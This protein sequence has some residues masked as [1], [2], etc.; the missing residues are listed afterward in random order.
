MI[1]AIENAGIATSYVV[2]Y[3]SIGSLNTDELIQ[4]LQARVIAREYLEQASN[5]SPVL[6]QKLKLIKKSKYYDVVSERYFD[7]LITFSGLS[8]AFLFIFHEYV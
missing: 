8:K 5:F 3:Y 1:R 6:A 2:Q 7:F 4:F